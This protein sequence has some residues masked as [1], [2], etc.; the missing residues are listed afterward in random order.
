MNPGWLNSDEKRSTQYETLFLRG[1]LVD[2]G[3]PLKVA[4]W[5]EELLV[6]LDVDP[7]DFPIVVIGNKVHEETNVN[8]LINLMNHTVL[9]LTCFISSTRVCCFLLTKNT[10]WDI[11]ITVIIFKRCC[12]ATPC[13]FGLGRTRSWPG[14]SSIDCLCLEFRLVVLDKRAFCSLGVSMVMSAIWL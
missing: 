8:A 2:G 12:S 5:R 14:L 11:S 9:V 6:R 4:M 3:V 1:A 7:H 13:Y 10:K